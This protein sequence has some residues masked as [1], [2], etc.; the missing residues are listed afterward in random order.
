[1]INDYITS[2]W[3]GMWDNCIDNKL[4]NIQPVL[5]ERLPGCQ[6]SRRDQV[7]LTRCRIG[8]GRLTH[9]YLLLNE[10]APVCMS[11]LCQLTIKHVLLECTDFSDIRG[12]YFQASSLRELFTQTNSSHIIEFLRRTG[13]Y[14]SI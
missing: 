4:N 11:C 2:Q 6:L 14:F 13:L 1:M 12:L 9:A 10:P 7:V 3:Q 8:H 5:A